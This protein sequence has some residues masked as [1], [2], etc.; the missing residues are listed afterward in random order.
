MPA[1][2]RTIKE[3]RVIDPGTPGAEQQTPARPK[4]RARRAGEQIKT[5]ATPAPL[6]QTQEQQPEIITA[7]AEYEATEEDEY[8]DQEPEPVT[9]PLPTAA[10]PTAPGSKRDPLEAVRQYN[11][12]TTRANIPRQAHPSYYSHLNQDENFHGYAPQTTSAKG[13]RPEA[14]PQ[15]YRQERQDDTPQRGNGRASVIAAG[16]TQ[17]QEVRTQPRPA[18]PLPRRQY[19]TDQPTA[20]QRRTDEPAPRRRAKTAP[21]IGRTLIILGGST[22]ILILMILS[23]YLAIVLPNTLQRV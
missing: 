1:T 8:E 18:Q 10:P 13:Y 7:V 6:A 5:T 17:I 22:T 14:T 15:Q 11:A 16:R 23:A 9:D 19:T 21:H 3:Q 4:V 12:T 20:Q 2:G